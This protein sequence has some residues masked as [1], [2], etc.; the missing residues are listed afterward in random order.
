[1]VAVTEAVEHTWADG[2]GV[3]WAEVPATGNRMADAALARRRI[4]AELAE[5]GES[6]DYRLRVTRERITGHGTTIYREA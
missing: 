6:R 2:Y 1:M 5:R 3:W 4:R